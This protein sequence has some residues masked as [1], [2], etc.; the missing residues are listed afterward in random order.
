MK[1]R[2]YLHNRETVS[3]ERLIFCDYRHSGRWRFSTGIVILPK[4][5]NEAKQRSKPKAAYS[6]DINL[7]LDAIENRIMSIAY[8]LVMER[9]KPLP[10]VVKREYESNRKGELSVW[11][12]WERFYNEYVTGLKYRTQ[13]NY[14]QAGMRWKEFE[15]SE[16]HEL[17]FSDMNESTFR[18]FSAFLSS[19][20]NNPNTISGRITK[21]KAFL[22]YVEANE[23]ANVPHSR[24]KV[25]ASY[26]QTSSAIF[27]LE[28]E[29]DSLFKT[30]MNSEK[31]GRVVDLFL[32]QA[33][34]GF[35]YSDG[36][37]LENQGDTDEIVF[38]NVKSNKVQKRFFTDRAR[39]I[40]QKYGG[41]IPEISNQKYNDY[42]KEAAK[43]AGLNRSVIH[44]G[45]TLPL[46]KSIT[47]H[48]ARHTLAERLRRSGADLTVI[49]SILGHSSIKTTMSYFHAN[50]EDERDAFRNL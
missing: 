15:G 28:S 7:N 10:K 49:Q 34:T 46:W 16:G 37:A 19:R 27:L 30:D 38:Q 6:H 25:K 3:G 50:E 11:D 45:E 41:E 36:Q 29:L 21:W 1:V 18:R 14:R 8:D 2:F 4:F 39:R 48:T 40:Y 23:W 9:K 22:N 24:H 20:G 26:K 17:F 35:R 47:T 31:L 43:I 44:R 33:D 5:W 32:F 12:A 42:I 13:I